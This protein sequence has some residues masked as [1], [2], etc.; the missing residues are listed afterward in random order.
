MTKHEFNYANIEIRQDG[1]IVL[2]PM[3]KEDMELHDLQMAVG[4]HIEMV[5]VN[6]LEL[7]GFKYYMII[8]DECAIRPEFKV[9]ML[10]SRLYDCNVPF[11]AFIYGD[12]VLG[13]HKTYPEPD[14]YNMPIAEAKKL[15]EILNDWKAVMAAY[16]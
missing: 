13:V 9:N 2:R 4:G 10:A 15:L 5:R 1:T 7:A 12:V 3:Q 11:S 8:N 14:V 16:D 6:N